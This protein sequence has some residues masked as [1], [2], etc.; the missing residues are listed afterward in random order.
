MEKIR[1]RFIR[2]VAVIAVYQHILIGDNL[3]DIQ[4]FIRL[5]NELKKNKEEVTYCNDFF[6]NIIKNQDTISEVIQNNL[7]EGWTN[8]RLSKM[9]LSILLVAAYELLYTE[10]NKEIVINEA[11]KLTKKYCDHGS[12]KYING[13]LNKI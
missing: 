11:V 7:K 12:Y 13:V 8:E 1:I 6:L 4:L 2:E 5:N 10:N 9:E 3:K